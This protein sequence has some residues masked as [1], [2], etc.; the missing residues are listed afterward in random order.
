VYACNKINQGR[1]NKSVNYNYLEGDK[2]VD[3]NEDEIAFIFETPGEG[4]S[5]RDVNHVSKKKKE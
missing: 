1:L 2:E 4:R 3:P 5:S